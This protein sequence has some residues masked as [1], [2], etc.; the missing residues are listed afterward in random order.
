MH[1]R[2]SV[3]QS[4]EGAGKDERGLC[5]SRKCDGWQARCLCRVDRSLCSS[6]ESYDGAC[7]CRAAIRSSKIYE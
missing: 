4:L 1:A 6:S 5:S 3:K 7:A 2:F